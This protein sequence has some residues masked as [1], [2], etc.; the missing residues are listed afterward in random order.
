M[1]DFG[2]MIDNRFER[3]ASFTMDEI[4]ELQRLGCVKASITGSLA[5][6]VET[7]PFFDDYTI[8]LD[9]LLTMQ[10]RAQNAVERITTPGF[11]SIAVDKYLNMLS[12]AIDSQSEL[13]AIC[14]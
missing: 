6:G 5:D 4:R 11:K 2:I 9:V 14:D 1:L 7:L 12:S 3:I 10:Q 13:L 8:A